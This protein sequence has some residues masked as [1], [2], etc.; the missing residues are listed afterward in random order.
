MK[1]IIAAFFSFVLILTFIPLVVF[2]MNEPVPER[3]APDLRPIA[4]VDPI[5]EPEPIMIPVM[6]HGTNTLEHILLEDYVKGVVASEMPASF[7]LEAL[8]AQAVAARTFGLRTL[9]TE[10]HIYDTVMDQVFRDESQLRE[11]WG[12]DF[13]RHFAHVAQAVKE[14]EGLVMAYR[15]ELI[16]A[17]F[18]AMSNGRTENSEDAFVSKR[19]YLR[20][21]ESLW[22]LQAPRFEVEQEFTLAEIR[23][24]F[25][26]PSLDFGSMTILS[27]T[28]GGN[29]NE[30]QVGETVLRGVEFRRMLGLRSAD[31][32]LSQRDNNIV[33]TTRGNGHGVGMSQYGANGMAKQGKTFDYILHFYYQGIEIIEKY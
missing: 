33:I 14:T 30:I 17:M 5:D 23:Q 25:G 24:L 18:F 26:N 4:V 21:V 31:F 8:K 2:L 7:E 32:S 28:A 27:R 10:P 22:D 3:K 1:N 29:V 15:G 20:S 12:N 13:E 16:N 9:L 6:R 19:P 11:K